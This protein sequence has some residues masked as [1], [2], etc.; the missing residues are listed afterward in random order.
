MTAILL[1]IF[2]AGQAELDPGLLV[3]IEGVSSLIVGPQVF[4]VILVTFS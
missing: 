2:V 1:T 4:H 3:L